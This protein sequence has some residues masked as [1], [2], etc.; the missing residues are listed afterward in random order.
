[1]VVSFSFNRGRLEAASSSAVV[2]QRVMGMLGPGGG[3]G[4]DGGS[5]QPRDGVHESVFDVVGD[6]MG[7][8]DGQGGVDGDGEFGA[9]AVADPAHP[10][11]ARGEDAFAGE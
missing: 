5:G 4:V 10:Y 8:L 2:G 3:F 7:P 9:Q 6:V 1:M 11:L